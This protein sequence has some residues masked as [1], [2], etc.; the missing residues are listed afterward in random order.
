MKIYFHKYQGTGNDFIMIDNRLG[1]YNNI[2]NTQTV[3]YLCNRRFGIGADGL[4]L[5][6]NSDDAAFKMRYFNSDGQEA[7]MC[8]NGGRCIAAFAAKLKIVPI[9]TIF[10][11]D[12]VDGK[13][14]AKVSNTIVSLKMCDVREIKKFS[15]GY[16]LDTGS[17][18][19][20][21]LCNNVEEI[22]VFSEGK[23]S[24]NDARFEDI[25]GANVNFLTINENKSLSVRTFERGVEDETLS[26]G[27]GSVASAIVAYHLDKTRSEFDI[28]VLGGY[29]K[30]KLKEQPDGTIEDIWLEGAA[31]FVFE[32]FINSNKE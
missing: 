32:G 18:H 19:F 31:E 8:G 16:F 24:R 22:D 23:K 9:N 15:D 14:Q 7:S 11:F 28:K 13:H 17:P 29:L 3:E 26:C 30:V 1:E 21:I 12:A 4:I 25:G 5:M 6:E 20:V 27:T 2:I 10:D